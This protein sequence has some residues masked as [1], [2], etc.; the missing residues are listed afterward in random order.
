M[1][2][3][4]TVTGFVA[5]ALALNER[6]VQFLKTDRSHVAYHYVVVVA[7]FWADAYLTLL[8][9]ADDV[10]CGLVQGGVT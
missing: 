1:N 4:Q 2:I 8:D 9:R 10:M 7:V 3:L 6:V 5:L